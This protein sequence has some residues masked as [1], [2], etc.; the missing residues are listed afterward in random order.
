MSRLV[1]KIEHIVV[2]VWL[3]VFQ[4]SDEG[5]FDLFDK[6]DLFDYLVH[7]D[8]FDGME[9]SHGQI[10][11]SLVQFGPN[12]TTETQRAFRQCFT[13]WRWSLSHAGGC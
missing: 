9:R 11:E 7:V 6:F 1:R 8:S 3:M 2:C 10:L 4:T 5:W 13:S 12:T